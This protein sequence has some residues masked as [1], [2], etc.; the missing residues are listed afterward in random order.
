MK[1]MKY[2]NEDEVLIL[3]V[4]MTRD[5]VELIDE[6]IVV[7]RKSGQIGLN[8]STILRAAVL[9]FFEQPNADLSGRN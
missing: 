6:C 5:M 8:R 9:S 4:R 7:G 3:S 1:Y 2:K